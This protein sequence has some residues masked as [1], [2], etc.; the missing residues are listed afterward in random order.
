MFE[1]KQPDD[2]QLPVVINVRGV[3]FRFFL[4]ENW[5]TLSRWFNSWPFY[6]LVKRSLTRWKG[7][8]FAIPKR[9][10]SQNP[11]GNGCHRESCFGQ[12]GKFGSDW[13]VQK[14]ND[15]SNKPHKVHH[16]FQKIHRRNHVFNWFEWIENR[17]TWSEVKM[18]WVGC[19][20]LK[21]VGLKFRNLVGESMGRVSRMFKRCFLLHGHFRMKWRIELRVGIILL[22][23][24]V[25]FFVHPLKFARF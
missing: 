8:V 22:C 13:W 24:F 17:R 6:P 16:I 15:N 25:V 10:R 20:R 21:I 14:N 18:L 9:S 19:G 3:V 11:R 5:M 7:H 12:G 4:F 1:M 2:V 23:M